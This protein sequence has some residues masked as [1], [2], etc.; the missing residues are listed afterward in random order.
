MWSPRQRR[1]RALP[2]LQGRDVTFVVTPVAGEQKAL[3]AAGRLPARDLGGHGDRCR[4]RRSTF[5]DGTGTTPG[6]GTIPPIAVPDPNDKINSEQQGTT[7]TC[8]LPSPALFVPD[9]P[10]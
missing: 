3:G 1:P 5:F 8:T 2:D 9:T 6:T 10:T 4:R 7:R